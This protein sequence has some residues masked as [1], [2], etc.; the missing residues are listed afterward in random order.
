MILIRGVPY[1]IWFIL[2][3][4]F[5]YLYGHDSTKD[6][7][8]SESFSLW[9]KSPKKGAESEIKRPLTLL[10]DIIHTFFTPA[11]LHFF[12][13]TRVRDQLEEQ[14]VR[15]PILDRNGNMIT[16]FSCK[17]IFYS[18]RI[19]KHRPF[20]VISSKYCEFGPKIK[21]SPRDI[22]NSENL[23]TAKFR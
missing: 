12:S 2:F 6:G 17:K 20:L 4:S 21:N 1:S 7:L 3:E 14:F 8:I 10:S 23:W 15:R 16:H 22:W 5:I 18:V 19:S 11:P 13:E 9:F